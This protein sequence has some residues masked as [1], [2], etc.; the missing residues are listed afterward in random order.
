M[1]KVTPV[2]VVTK[3]GQYLKRKAAINFRK[4]IR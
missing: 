1:M 3:G 4:N 2:Y